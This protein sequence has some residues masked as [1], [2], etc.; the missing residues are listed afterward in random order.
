MAAVKTYGY[1]DANW[2]DKLTSYNGQTITYDEIGNPTYYYN[3]LSLDWENGRQLSSGE[4]G[5]AG[6]SFSYDYNDAGL[7]VQKSAGGYGVTDYYYNGDQLLSQVNGNI[8]MDFLYDDAES[9]IGF[10]YNGTAYYYIRNLQNDIIGILDS[11]GNQV[12]SYVYDSW[13]KLIST[14]GSLVDTI[15]FQNPFRYRGYYYDQETGWY[16]LQSRYYDPEIGRFINPDNIS[17]ASG[18]LKS[19]VNKNMYAY[20]DNSPIICEDTEGEFWHLVAGAA[21]GALLSGASQLISNIASGREWHEGMV[22]AVAVGAV[23]GFISATGFGP[24]IQGVGNTLASAGGDI[25]QQGIDKGFNNID[26]IQTARVA[27]KSGISNAAGGIL[28]NKLTKGKRNEATSRIEKGTS[29]QSRNKP[30]SAGYKRGTENV[31]YGTQLQNQARFESSSYGSAVSAGSSA[32][33]NS[34]SSSNKKGTW[35]YPGVYI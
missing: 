9:L 2:K 28:G 23:T 26:Y 6:G 32:I 13:G 17:L 27:I 29:R 20:C 12:V 25:L 31:A 34:F 19:V 3:G 11:D 4:T 33:Y 24:V 35:C 30:G 22:S 5:A 16:Y 7:R 15:G 18:S 10:L 8:Q 21:V 1:E 14:S